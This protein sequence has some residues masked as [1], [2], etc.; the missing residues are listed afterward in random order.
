MSESKC[1]VGECSALVY[2]K[3]LCRQH[4]KRQW[5][6]GTTGAGP[7]G[8]PKGIP[9][10]PECRAKISAAHKGI[11]RTSDQRLRIAAAMTG[12]TGPLS[13]GWKGDAVGY[14]VAHMRHTLEL[15][16]ECAHCGKTDGVLDCA[17]RH[18]TPLDRLR[19]DAD[20]TNAGLK[21]S[22]DVSDYMR[23]CRRCHLI[24]DRRRKPD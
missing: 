18:E 2:A 22:L 10:S 15:P 23:L 7:V 16:R 3:G 8:H 20:G 19:A 24:Y 1:L 5:R 21:F 11:P 17:L 13:N 9:L 14:V 6:T 12:R 4:Y